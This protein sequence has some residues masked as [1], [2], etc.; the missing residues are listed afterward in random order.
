LQEI[1]IEMQSGQTTILTAHLLFLDEMHKGKAQLAN[2][3]Q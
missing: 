2:N 1:E 3:I